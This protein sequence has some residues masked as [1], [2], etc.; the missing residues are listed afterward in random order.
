MAELSYQQRNNSTLFPSDVIVNTPNSNKHDV[1]CYSFCYTCCIVAFAT[2][3]QIKQI[4]L[5]ALLAIILLLAN[6]SPTYSSG[7]PQGN[8]F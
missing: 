4:N 8:V 6:V 7:L 3:F 5:L 1:E 2:R